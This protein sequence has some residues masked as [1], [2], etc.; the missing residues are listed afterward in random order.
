MSI[1][2]PIRPRAA[3]NDSE[4]RHHV[5]DKIVN[6]EYTRTQRRLAAIDYSFN[7]EG[8]VNI[9][10]NYPWQ[11]FH[12][13]F[14]RW[15]K[16]SL[17]YEVDFL[18]FLRSWEITYLP[19]QLLDPRTGAEVSQVTG[20][21]KVQAQSPAGN[22]HF[23]GDPHFAGVLSVMGDNGRFMSIV[24]SLRLADHPDD[25]VN[26]GHQARDLAKTMTP[27]RPPQATLKDIP[28]RYL[29]TLGPW[30]ADHPGKPP[31]K[32]VAGTFTS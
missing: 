30:V 8:I 31:R 14:G 7:A 25:H 27:E 12:Y 3:L 4:T 15:Q 29:K 23:A 11:E 16:Q 2:A 1:D 28:K 20:P 19:L 18:P 21:Y 32:G 9:L 17:G 26:V 10:A 22:L 5:E 6:A 13:K 24:G